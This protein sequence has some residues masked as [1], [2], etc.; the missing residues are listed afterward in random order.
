VRFFGRNTQI[1]EGA[2]VDLN[3]NNAIKPLRTL[4]DW[5][6]MYPDLKVALPFRCS[7]GKKLGAMPYVSSE[8]I[9]IES[10]VCDCPLKDSFVAGF[11]KNKEQHQ[12]AINALRKLEKE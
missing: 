6:N 9:G 11:P 5:L 2:M 1:G 7:C 8:W 3:L 12:E 10:T 4:K